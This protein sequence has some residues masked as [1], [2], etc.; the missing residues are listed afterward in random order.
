MTDGD[1]DFVE[2]HRWQWADVMLR[3]LLLLRIKHPFEKVNGR[4]LGDPETANGPVCLV[5]WLNCWNMCGTNMIKRFYLEIVQ[6]AML[7]REQS[8]D[9]RT[10]RSC[11]HIAQE[12]SCP[13][14][15]R[16]PPIVLLHSIEKQYSS[17]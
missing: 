16:D 15:V 4:F 6:T 14:I 3:C 12:A 13:A 2:P 9:K 8:R 17:E 11:R 10:F 7:A 1:G 5:V